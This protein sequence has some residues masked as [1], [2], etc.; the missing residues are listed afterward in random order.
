MLLLLLGSP[1][2]AKFRCDP[3]K[4][5]VPSCQ[6]FPFERELINVQAINGEDGFLALLHFSLCMWDVVVATIIINLL[7]WDAHFYLITDVGRERQKSR[8]E[9]KIQEDN[10]YEPLGVKGVIGAE[11]KEYGS[12]RKERQGVRKCR[13]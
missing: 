2:V 7:S 5:I 13:K 11:R 1:T 8:R 4:I 3:K 6:Q 9:D 10:W 12:M